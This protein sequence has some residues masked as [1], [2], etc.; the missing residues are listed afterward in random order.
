MSFKNR[1][2]EGLA[3]YIYEI[4][5]KQGK[6]SFTIPEPLLRNTITSLS[7]YYLTSTKVQLESGKLMISGMSL[8]PVSVSIFE[9]DINNTDNII[10]FKIAY[11]KSLSPFLSTF[12]NPAISK[13]PGLSFA[14]DTISI[15]MDKINDSVINSILSRFALKNVKFSSDGISIEI[16][17]R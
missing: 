17:D 11:N 1:F 9:P 4:I 15:N 8:I 2:L 3:R 7:G 14:N 12:L 6:F 13:N 10:S 16:A 5:E